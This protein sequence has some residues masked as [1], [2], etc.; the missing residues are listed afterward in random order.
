[1]GDVLLRRPCCSLI[2][3][4]WKILFSDF[5]LI[6]CRSDKKKQHPREHKISEGEMN[7]K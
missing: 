1:M 5:F 3:N 6:L 2:P 4:L 7:E